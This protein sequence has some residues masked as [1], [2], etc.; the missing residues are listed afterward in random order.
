M[1]KNEYQLEQFKRF[2]GNAKINDEIASLL[3]EGEDKTQILYDLCSDYSHVSINSKK[4]KTDKLSLG[5][6]PLEND[7]ELAVSS[8]LDFINKYKIDDIEGLMDLICE[9]H[10]HA[11][12]SEDS[13]KQKSG[14]LKDDSI[15]MGLYGVY[16]TFNKLPKETFLLIKERILKELRR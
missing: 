10:P 11:I 6:L 4:V 5:C 2:L 8:T 14:M 13:K 7:I 1:K 12:K 9:L 3:A 15:K 16:F